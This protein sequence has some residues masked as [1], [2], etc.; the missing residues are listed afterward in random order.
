MAS[1]AVVLGGGGTVGIAWEIGLLTGLHRAGVDIGAA[2]LI[3]GTSAGSVVGTQIALGLP[4][5]F[6]L[7]AQLAPLDAVKAAPISFDTHSLMAIGVLWGSTAEMTPALAAE[8][9]ALALKSKTDTEDVYLQRFESVLDGLAWP[10]RPLRITAVDVQSGEIVVWDRNS[11]APLARAVASSCAV[12]GLFPPVT[13]NGRRYMDGGIRSG[14]SADLAHGHDVII[15]IAPI[16]A[17]AEA[18]DQMARRQFEHEMVLLRAEGS[19]V[20]LVLPDQESL[21]AFGPNLMDTTRRALAAQ[22]GL[23][24]GALAAEAIRKI[25]W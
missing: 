12:P 23:C 3:V 8:I 4:L 1:R 5:D 9:G 11:G 21:A 17:T 19:V 22:A 16:G 6:Q 15:I 7:A 13:I 20:E 18:F 10:Q 25:G 2:D 14:T 24:Q